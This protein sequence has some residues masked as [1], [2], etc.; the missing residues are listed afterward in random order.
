M[1]FDREGMPVYPVQIKQT[2]SSQLFLR[3]SDGL[4]ASIP[5]TVLRDSCPCAGCKGETV[6]FKKSD[7]LLPILGG[8]GKYEIN[9]MEQV[10]NYAVQVVWADGHSTGIYTWDYLRTLCTEQE[11]PGAR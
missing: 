1:N 5:L 9:A 2:N 11:N 6:L 4:D 7:P 8:P 10:G 3:W